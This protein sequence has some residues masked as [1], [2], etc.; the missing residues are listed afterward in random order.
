MPWLIAAD[1]LVHNG[2]TTGLEARMLGTPVI[3]YERL[4][5]ESF[6]LHL[7]NDVSRQA[8]DVGELVKLIEEEIRDSSAAH[9]EL[10]PQVR[11]IIERYVAAT[12]G[13]LAADRMCDALEVF[14]EQWR[15]E[16]PA[17]IWSRQSGRIHGRVRGFEKWFNLMRS[18]HNNSR[19]YL[20]HVFAELELD[21]M[22]ELVSRFRSALGR[23]GNVRVRPHSRNVFELSAT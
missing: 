23:F 12:R 5:S 13:R 10:P 18:Q 20:E 2:C 21:E 1:A 7:P 11:Q 9:D 15:H 8:R 14:A 4:T 19:S 6:D 3:S 16:P 22:E 17:S